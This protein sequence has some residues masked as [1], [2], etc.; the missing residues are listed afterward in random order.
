MFKAAVVERNIRNKS[1]YQ[2]AN[3]SL[4]VLN[5]RPFFFTASAAIVMGL[6]RN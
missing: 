3:K 4:F 2:S 6:I 5:F 1:T